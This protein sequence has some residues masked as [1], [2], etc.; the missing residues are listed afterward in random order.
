MMRNISRL[1]LP[2]LVLALVLATLVRA[3]TISAVTS[4]RTNMSTPTASYYDPSKLTIKSSGSNIDKCWVKFDLANLAKGGIADYLIGGL[5]NSDIV[6]DTAVISLYL[7]D[8]TAARTFDISYL[9][10]TTTEN[11]NWVGSKTDPLGLTW[12]N[13]PGNDTTSA[14]ALLASK[15]VLIQNCSVP[16]TDGYRVQVDVKSFIADDSDGIV[17][18]VLH[19]SSG[20]VDIA[21]HAV[22]ATYNPPSL[23]PALEITY[24]VVPE[25]ATLAVLALGGLLLRRRM[26]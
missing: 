14:S 11:I 19:N 23:P 22:S 4:S 25:P 3:N 8:P 10:D 24:H 16:A 12:N 5:R 15:A 9:K 13:A 2:A 26:A 20:Q 7:L 18:F 1:S 6:I 17:Q 21:A